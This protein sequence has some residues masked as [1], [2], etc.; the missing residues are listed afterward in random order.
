M[1]DARNIILMR[2]AWTRARAVM[3]HII[4]AF[5][6]ADETVHIVST[7]LVLN[8]NV[9]FINK[10]PTCPF[11]S[12]R[13]I[14]ETTLDRRDLRC[15]SRRGCCEC[16]VAS[17]IGPLGRVSPAFPRSFERSFDGRGLGSRVYN[18]GAFASSVG[19]SERGRISP[20]HV[21]DHGPPSPSPHLPPHL[22]IDRVAPHPPP[23]EP[24]AS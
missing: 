20:S 14:L 10:E 5:A 6:G 21:T 9:E 12:R 19:P 2:T 8:S 4:H 13:R 3:L 17:C 16:F 15:G 22:D 24:S 1:L 18:T 11:P 7:I 23:T